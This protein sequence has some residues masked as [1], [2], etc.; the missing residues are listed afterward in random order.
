MASGNGST[1]S[2]A[3]AVSAVAMGCS[4]S[5]A[6]AALDAHFA[7]H[8]ALPSPSSKVA[9]LVADAGVI[10]PFAAAVSALVVASALVLLPR[11][12]PTLLSLAGRLRDADPAAHRSGSW[13]AS[14]WLAGALFALVATA[15]VTRRILTWDAPPLL[16]GSAMSTGTVAILLFS[17]ALVTEARALLR[18]VPKAVRPE[19]V[20]ALVSVLVAAALAHG[21]RTGTTNGDG[22]ALQILG[23]LRREELD[24]RAPALLLGVALAAAIGMLLPARRGFLGLLLSGAAASLGATAYAARS[25]AL[26]ERAASLAL[27]RGAPLGGRALS[28]LRRLT[29]RDRDGTSAR[30]GGGDC[31]DHDPTRY[32]GAD[33]LPGNGKDEDCSGTDEVVSS[34]VVSP[35]R[36]PAARGAR[37]PAGLSLVLITVDT[38]RA[39]LGFS[40]YSRPISPNLDAL[41][42]RSVVFDRAYSLA[43]YTGKSMGP[44]LLGKYPSE[45]HRNFGHFDRFDPEET[46]VQERL[47]R[48]GV[49]TLTA[50]AHWYFKPESGLGR[51]FDVSDQSAMPKVPQAEGDRTVNGDKLTDAAI[52]VLSKSDNTAGRFYFWMHYIDP[53]AEYVFHPELDFGRKGRDLY[54]GEVA[55]VDR[56]VGRLLSFLHESG[57]ESRTAIIVTSDHG[58]AFAE[59]GML[60]HGFEVWEELVRVPLV[61]HVPGLPPRRVPLPRSAVDVVP[62]ILELFGVPP[63]HGSGADFVSGTSLAP[64][65]VP[66]EG[67]LE[68]RPVLVDMSEGPYNE[69]RQAFVDGDLKLIATRGRP[70]GLYDLA[71]DPG[72]KQDLLGDPARAAPILARFRAMRRSLRTVE[73]R[74]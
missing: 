62:T 10:A 36:P 48:A 43:S 44:L 71:K 50:Q 34:A 3:R 39:D 29:D 73:P 68:P 61:V 9:L 24:L 74:R 40:G 42:A 32:P 69:E 37:L 46:F 20:V 11:P 23:V 67:P 19:L 35:A 33:D 58:E 51:G 30:F 1:G 31:D 16:V 65:L 63:P 21:I 4:A 64:D 7:Y 13:L 55:F 72:E 17:S 38:L 5:F 6:V 60:R 47:R 57:L 52:S 8:S 26:S 27:E 53:H 14:A 54:D 70:L 66:G 56:Q 28:V 12:L 59:H 15:H 45:T 49:R 41:A 18:R 2:A 25:P 22:G